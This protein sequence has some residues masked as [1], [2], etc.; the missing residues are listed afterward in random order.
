MWSGFRG[1]LKFLVLGL[2]RLNFLIEFVLL[3]D[4]RV[5][6]PLLGTFKLQQEKLDVQVQDFWVIDRL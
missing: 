5:K 1:F 3:I 2:L 6:F 4:Y